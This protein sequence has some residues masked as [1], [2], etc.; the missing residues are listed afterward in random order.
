MAKKQT[1]RED[2]ELPHFDEMWAEALIEGLVEDPDVKG[3]SNF[4]SRIPRRDIE[5]SQILDYA[6][7]HYP[8]LSD[9]EAFVK[10]V[11]RSLKHAEADDRRQDRKLDALEKDVASIKMNKKSST[12]GESASGGATAAGGIASVVAGGNKNVGTLFGGTYNQA[13][14]K[15]TKK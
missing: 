6:K 5:V 3:G 10:Y 1:I 13:K 8:G 14:K 4:I 7:D 9:Q 12:V 11:L 15:R 2:F